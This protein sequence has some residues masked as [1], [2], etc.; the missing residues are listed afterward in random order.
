MPASKRPGASPIRTLIDWFARPWRRIVDRSD[1]RFASPRF[2]SNWRALALRGHGT[3]C[4]TAPEFDSGARPQPRPPVR[5]SKI[6]HTTATLLD[7]RARMKGFLLAPGMKSDFAAQVLATARKLSDAAAEHPDSF[8]FQLLSEPS[9]RFAIYSITH[10]MQCAVACSLVAR[11]MEWDRQRSDSL[12]CAALTMN[13]GMARLQGELAGQATPPT[14]EQLQLIYDHP[15]NSIEMLR[16]RGVTDPLWLRAVLEHHETPDGKGYPHGIRAGF[17]PAEVLRHVDI[18]LA[19]LKGRASR[20]A[21]APN[22]AILEIFVDNSD[23][24]IAS[25]VIKE[26]GLYPPG[27]FVRLESGELGV[28]VARGEAVN[29]PIVSVLVTQQGEAPSHRIQRDTQDPRFAVSA[30]VNGDNVLVAVDPEKLFA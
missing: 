5:I 1:P 24:R 28:V 2:A 9:G 21:M 16:Q 17:E 18:F 7:A 20:R 29:K 26:F 23:S 27:M 25:A 10:A 4:A 11:R 12:A 8:L 19:K 22:Q 6:Q 3:D 14:N 30:L 13:I 15:Q